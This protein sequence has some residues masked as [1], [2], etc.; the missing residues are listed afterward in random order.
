MT[1]A[2]LPAGVVRLAPNVTFAATHIAALN[3][4]ERAVCA[5][6]GVKSGRA[7]MLWSRDA[8]SPPRIKN[9]RRN[10]SKKRVRVVVAGQHWLTVHRPKLWAAFVAARL[11][12]VAEDFMPQVEQD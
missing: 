5:A 12:G 2:G 1:P 4:A 7:T 3:E 11:A 8:Y 6:A 10:S 9:V